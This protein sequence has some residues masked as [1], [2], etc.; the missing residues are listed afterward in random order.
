MALT[1]QK[2][3]GV[4]LSKG[5][6]GL[7]RILVGLGWDIRQGSGLNFDLDASV[8]LL[9]SRGK[10]SQDDDF[11]FYN[12]LVSRC[13]SVKHTGDNRTGE[14]EGDDE[15]VEID[16]DQVPARVER[17]MICVT[18]HEADT[19]RQHFGQVESAFVRIEDR[20]SGIELVRFDLSDD[21]SGETAVLFGEVVRE[22][23]GWGFNA[24][25]EGLQAD[26][27]DLCMR[28]GVNVA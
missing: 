20:D 2:G 24:V 23:G 16:L 17:I 6:P 11:I 1:L 9:N 18:I 8:F 12:N 10:V 4:S 27:G 13:G 7:R 25:G 26:L 28:F 21:Y 5:T 14:G 15:S 19:R 3:R 22:K